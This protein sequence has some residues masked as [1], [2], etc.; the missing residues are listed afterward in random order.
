VVPLRTVRLEIDLLGVDDAAAF[1]AY[2]GIPEVAV[3]Q[4]WTPD[5]SLPDA[6]R[7]VE[8]QRSA[9]VPPV[10]PG[11]WVQLAVRNRAD[12]SLLGDVAVGRDAQ[13]DTFEVGVT[14]APAHHGHGYATEAVA[15]VVDALFAIAG[16]HRVIAHGDERNGAVR[17][18]LQRVGFRHESRAVDADWF[19]GEWTTLDTFALLARD[20]R[21]RW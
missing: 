17:A 18:L 4:S 9:V 14:F 10:E 8:G 20:E 2:R 11:H 19:K 7:L 15:A 12:G 3:Y 16:A 5:Y 21:H 13:P 6:L 1:A